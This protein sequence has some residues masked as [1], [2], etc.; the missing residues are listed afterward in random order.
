M[1]NKILCALILPLTAALCLNCSVNTLVANALTGEG[2]S[3]VFTGDSDPEL[4]GDALPFAIKIYEAL[5]DST[6]KHQGLMQVTGSLF[7]MYANAYVQGPA[8]ILPVQEWQ[9]REEGLK[10]AKRLYLRGNAI[11]YRALNQKYRGFSDAAA[12]EDALQAILKKCKKEDAGLLY[13]AVAGGLA[14]FSIDVFDFDL[15]ARIPEWKLMIERAYELDPHYGGAALDEFFILFYGSLPELLGGDKER[16]KLHFQ[17]AVE[18]TGGNSAGAYISYAQSI[19][20]PAHDYETF[21]DCLEKALAIDPDAD[22][23]TRLVTIISQRK[24]QWMLDHAWNYFSFLP[25]PADY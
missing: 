11:L 23:S 19:C 24:A 1:N 16:A 4:I 3:T 13:W 9:A 18:K 5:L 8:E 17:R 25:I 7:I 6:P 21:K 14:A 12:Q 10:R 20:V 22:T 2:S 15:L